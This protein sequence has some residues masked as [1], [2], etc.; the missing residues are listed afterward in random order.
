MPESWGSEVD[1]MNSQ[2]DRGLHR[3]TINRKTVSTY[4]RVIALELACTTVDASAM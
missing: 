1:V 4:S 2:G 3:E